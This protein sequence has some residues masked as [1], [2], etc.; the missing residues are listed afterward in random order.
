MASNGALKG[1]VAKRNAL[2]DS[3]NVSKPVFPAASSGAV[4]KKQGTSITSNTALVAKAQENVGEQTKP[5][6]ALLRPAQRPISKTGSIVHSTSMAQIRTGSIDS[7]VPRGPKQQPLGWKR[8][9]KSVVYNDAQPEKDRQVPEPSNVA[10]PK[11]ADR[12]SVLPGPRPAARQPRHYQSQPVLKPA[13]P[14]PRSQL[15][16]DSKIIAVPKPQRGRVSAP[17]EKTDWDNSSRDGVVGERGRPDL[18][19]KPLSSIYVGRVEDDATDAPYLDAVEELPKEDQYPKP[20][21]IDQ[22]LAPIPS[23]PEPI[24]PTKPAPKTEVKSVDFQPDLLPPAHADDLPD[25]SD[26]DEDY[27]DDQGYTT[28]HSTRSRGD[29]TTGGV[30]TSLFPPKLTKK[31]ATEIEAAKLIVKSKRT[32]EEDAEEAW[33]VSMV[34]EY[35]DDIFT[36][37]RNLEVRVPINYRMYLGN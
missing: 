1:G 13:Q 19:S 9:A 6:D 24:M 34:A 25:L 12:D 18:T 10:R 22:P 29:N 17:S 5:K 31:D 30:T 35:G 32:P 36:Y 37:M 4:V 20:A 33:D 26:Y 23:L 14:G 7:Q 28:A 27:Y 15:A 16:N 3:S 2:A 21:S 8:P 11:K